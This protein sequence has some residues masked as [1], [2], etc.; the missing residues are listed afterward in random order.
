[1]KRVQR[2]LAGCM[3]AVL[4]M[5]M[6]AAAERP[7]VNRTKAPEIVYTGKA[8]FELTIELQQKLLQFIKLRTVLFTKAKQCVLQAGG[9]CVIEVPI[10][11]LKDPTG[12]EEYCVGLFPEEISITGTAPGNP[13]KT[14]VWSLIPPVSPPPNAKF[15][16][17]DDQAAVGKAPGII[18]LKDSKKQLH[19]G[20][21]GDGTVTPADPTKYLLKNKHREKGK[22]V[23]I[24]V[25]VRTDD[26]GLATEKVSV[27]GTPDPRIAND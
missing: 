18:V 6:V 7:A 21:I 12:P 27:C 4:S 20:M 15:T 14:F 13:V 8:D 2:R 22:A 19:G 24:P 1:M 25:V 5:G 23:Y 26:A 10:I 11:L 16:F 17:F 9:V 3:L